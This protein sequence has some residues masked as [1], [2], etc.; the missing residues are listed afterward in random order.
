MFEK[1]DLKTEIVYPPPPKGSGLTA[2]PVMIPGLTVPWLDRIFLASMSAL[3]VSI[4][5]VRRPPEPI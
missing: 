1:T 2:A 5:I 3:V 4:V